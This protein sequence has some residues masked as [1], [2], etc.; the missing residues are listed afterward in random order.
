M[1]CAGVLELALAEGRSVVALVRKPDAAQRLR[2]LGVTVIEGDASD[3]YAVEQA[4][5][6][7][8]ESAAIISTLGGAQDYLAHR[9]IVDT[10]EKC[11]LSQMVMVTSLGCGDSWPTLSQR[12]R[13]AFGQAVREKSLAEIWLQTSTLDFAIVRPGGLL[14]GTATGL[15]Q[16]YQHQEVHGFVYRRD[17]ARVVQQLLAEAS[18][19]NQIYSLVQPEL[20]PAANK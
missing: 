10:A 8:G 16:L 19:N 7:A 15:A 18:L 6:T 11:G 13:A 4:C 5:Q 12:A 17:V 3:P 20:T 2:N 14:N 9:I 1:S